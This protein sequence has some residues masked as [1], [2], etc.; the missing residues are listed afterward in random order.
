MITLTHNIKPSRKEAFELALKAKSGQLS[1]VEIDSLIN[2]FAPSV[3]STPKTAFQWVARAVAVNDIRQ[4]LHFVHVSDG[5]MYATDGHRLH[6]AP[7]D[8]KNG[9]YDAKTGLPVDDKYI[10]G[11]FPDIRRVIPKIETMKEQSAPGAHGTSVVKGKSV[12]TIE[13]DGIIF[14]KKYVD[15]AAPEKI[16]TDHEKLRGANSFGECVIMFRKG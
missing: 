13:Y 4:Y 6:L 5:V 1:E 8:L 10:R 3:P 15:D 11:R 16:Y 7:T 12:F 9:Y 14:D 2:Y